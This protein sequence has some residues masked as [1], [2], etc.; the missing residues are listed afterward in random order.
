VE[1]DEDY[2]RSRQNGPLIAALLDTFDLDPVAT[3][4][5]LRELPELRD[6]FISDLFAL[7]IFLCDDLVAVSAESPS[8]S[9][10]SQQ[11]TRFF[12]IAQRLPIE[13]QMMISNRVFCSQK[14]IILTKHSEPAFKRLGR[15]LLR[16][17]TPE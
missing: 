5:Q 1:P 9:A 17:Q 14:S 13:L 4:Q 7:V 3:R 2:L 10:T 6:P 11:A 12:Q 15:L 16:G 8:S